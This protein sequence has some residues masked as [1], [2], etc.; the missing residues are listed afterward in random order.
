MVTGY[1]F[2]RAEHQAMPTILLQERIFSMHPEGKYSISKLHNSLSRSFTRTKKPN[3]QVRNPRVPGPGSY[4][5]VK[6]TD[7]G[8]Y[9]GTKNSAL[10]RSFQGR[11]LG[12]SK[13]G[14]RAGGRRGKN[15]NGKGTRTNNHQ[16][17]EI[18]GAK[19]YK[20]RDKSV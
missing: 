11:A 3:H 10:N 17:G 12:S 13:A 18:G 6:L 20:Q 8:Y 19:L 15:L 7:F 9:K 14:S 1:N 5:L 16:P 2:S 4:D